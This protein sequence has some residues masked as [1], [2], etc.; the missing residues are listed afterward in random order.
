MLYMP[1]VAW[2]CLQCRCFFH[3]Y[4]TASYAKVP[5]IPEKNEQ[6]VGIWLCW[7]RSL[8]SKMLLY[9]HNA[10]LDIYWIT[11]HPE[12]EGTHK[13]HQSNS[14]P[15]TRQA[16]ESHPVP[17]NGVQ[18]L[19]ELCQP[20]CCDQCPGE[21]VPVPNHPLDEEPF[22]NICFFKQEEPQKYLISLC[23]KYH[24]SFLLIPSLAI[25]IPVTPKDCPVLFYHS[26]KNSGHLTHLDRSSSGW[27]RSLPCIC[28]LLLMDR[29][30]TQQKIDLGHCWHSVV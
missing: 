7:F 18:R 29:T 16:Q 5:F 3:R 28:T 15:S 14:W 8:R 25:S 24:Y 23:I 27:L 9:K 12:M 4:V 2:T 21:L 13:N 1:I 6:K 20:W 26:P 19:L 10:H 11:E 30:L 22:P 17:E